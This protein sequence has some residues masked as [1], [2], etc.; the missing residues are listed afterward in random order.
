MSA[1]ILSRSFLSQLSRREF[2]KLSG[3]SALS[4]FWLPYLSPSSAAES[5]DAVPTMGRIT[6]DEANVYD[7]PSYDGN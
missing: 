6:D 3:T 2:L 1:N 4:L 7:R 5:P